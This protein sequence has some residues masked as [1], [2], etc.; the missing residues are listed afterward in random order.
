MSRFDE[1]NNDIFIPVKSIVKIRSSWVFDSAGSI[2]RYERGLED[3]KNNID[4]NPG[5][6]KDEKADDGKYHF[7]NDDGITYPEVNVKARTVAFPCLFWF[8]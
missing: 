5:S 7:L 2:Y 6:I 8:V 4:Y 1:Y 3:I